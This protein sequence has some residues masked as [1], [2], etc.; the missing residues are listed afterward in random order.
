MKSDDKALKAA[1]RERFPV[2]KGI[3][4]LIN[5]CNFDLYFGPIGPYCD[6]GRRWPGFSK[7]LEIIARHVDDVG[8]TYWESGCDYLSDHEP[9]GYTDEE[10][11]EYIPPYLDDT[12]QISRT[13]ALEILLGKE[14]VK[15]L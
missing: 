2:G 6:D 9:E 7:A 13:H 3:Q 14:L 15:Y 11:G 5:L 1:I 10:T 8:P 4:R 12:Y